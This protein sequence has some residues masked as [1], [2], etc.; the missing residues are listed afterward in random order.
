MSKI[1]SDEQIRALAKKL[2]Y[3]AG[4]VV[5]TP[6]RLKARENVLPVLDNRSNMESGRQ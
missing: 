6:E 4:R 5:N 3:K 1:L 2:Y